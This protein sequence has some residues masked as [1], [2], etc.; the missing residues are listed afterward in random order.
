[1]RQP[2][3]FDR[4]K[5]HGAYSH[6]SAQPQ[7]NRVQ[8]ACLERSRANQYVSVPVHAPRLSLLSTLSGNA[9]EL[10]IPLTWPTRPLPPTSPR[11][12]GKHYGWTH[13]SPATPSVSCA[14]PGATI[15]WRSSPRPSLGPTAWKPPSRVHGHLRAIASSAT[16]CAIWTRITDRRPVQQTRRRQQL[17]TSS[18]CATKRLPKTARQPNC[19]ARTSRRSSP[20]HASDRVHCSA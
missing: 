6:F 1:M 10:P 13:R 15:T 17:G 20:G 4:S 19:S 18:S 5:T 3:A 11:C 16:A 8:S 2:S 12:C 14:K 7:L 9:P